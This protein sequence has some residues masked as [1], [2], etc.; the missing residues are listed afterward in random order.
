VRL[1]TP[2]VVEMLAC[3]EQDERGADRRLVAAA[4]GITHAG[5]KTPAAFGVA[6]VWRRHGA[7]VYERV[8]ECDIPRL[9]G[10][11]L[12]VEVLAAARE[13]CLAVGHAPERRERL[14]CP[15]DARRAA[16]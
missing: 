2:E 16:D 12:A 10:M 7:A 14:R 3:P 6:D 4:G 15:A 11:E 5:E 8:P 9:E 1:E 13:S